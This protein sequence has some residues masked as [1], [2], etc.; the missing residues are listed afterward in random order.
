M[1]TVFLYKYK[2]RVRLFAQTSL[3]ILQGVDYLFAKII[4]Y[5]VKTKILPINLRLLTFIKE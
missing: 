3:Y 5:L 1:V 4:I 2:P